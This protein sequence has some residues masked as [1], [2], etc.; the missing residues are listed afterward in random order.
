MSQ[1][2]PEKTLASQLPI[3]VEK[4]E[5]PFID[6]DDADIDMAAPVFTSIDCDQKND[7]L[8]TE[9]RIEAIKY[10][11]R[12]VIKIYFLFIFEDFGQNFYTR[13]CQISTPR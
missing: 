5:N 4:D 1:T 6:I 11:K 9:R 2:N 10:W 12:Y 7:L 8:N 3:L 13:H